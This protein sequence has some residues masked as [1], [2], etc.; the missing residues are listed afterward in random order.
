MN[1]HSSGYTELPRTA[2]LDNTLRRARAAAEHR[3]H[4]YVTVEHLLLA[5]ADD[6]DA[7]RLLNTVGADVAVIRT[8][9]SDIVNHR[10]ASLAVPDARPPSF[11]YKFDTLFLSAS[12]DA[13]RAGRREVNGALI[14]IAVAKDPESTASAILTANGFHWQMGLQALDAPPAPQPPPLYPAAPPR[15]EASIAQRPEPAPPMRPAQSSPPVIPIQSPRASASDSLMEDM[16]ASVRN[17]LDAEERKERGLPPLNVPAPLQPP[18]LPPERSNPPPPSMERSG[19][20][21]REPQ[22]WAGAPR[23]G[24]RAPAGDRAGA[25]F[26]FQEADGYTAHGE[27]AAAPAFLSQDRR[28]PGTRGAISSDPL[29][30]G[31]DSEERQPP[32]P[33]KKRKSRGRGEQSGPLAKLLQDIPR[34]ARIGAAQTVQVQLAKEDA[35]YLLARAA[36][37]G[38]PQLGAES[39][40]ICRAVT[41]RLTAPEG[42]F[43]V[44]PAGPDTQWILNRSSL[45]GEEAF[46]SWEWTALPSATGSYSLALSISARE[47][48][49][50]GS[51]GDLQLPEQ[52]VKVRIRGSAG[53]LLWGLIRTVLLLSAGSGLTAGAWYAL[54]LMG[55]LPN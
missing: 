54:K 49:E 53:G 41:V 31:F 38:Q 8:A 12:E 16:L 22:F 40:P 47:L 43:F 44:E 33:D 45:P 36:R 19:P 26:H 50:N 2:Y 55:K 18:M 27:P 9:V 35:A 21:R 15:A 32:L 34:K 52:I 42:G 46:G 28:Q 30:T 10:M 20:P 1:D 4:R 11:S 39:Q 5:L 14:I 13:L 25:S 7:V 29:P 51:V 24:L 37:R 48:N 23:E 3:S 17:I 6:P